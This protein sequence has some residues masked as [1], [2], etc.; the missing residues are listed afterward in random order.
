MFN[1]NVFFT[2]HTCYAKPLAIKRKTIFLVTSNH[3]NLYPKNE[4]LLIKCRIG[5]YKEK[6]HY[7]SFFIL[8]MYTLWLSTM[9]KKILFLV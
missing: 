4:K 3:S 2:T 6:F 8:K 5:F 1:V 9:Y 7:I